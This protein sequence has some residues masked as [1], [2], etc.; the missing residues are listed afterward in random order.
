ML[1]VVDIGLIGFLTF[2]A[3]RDGMPHC[4]SSQTLQTLT[5]NSRRAGSLRITLLWGIGELVRGCR[6]ALAAGQ[7]LEEGVSGLV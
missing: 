2:H 5:P 7:W 6:I 3:Y 1:F 4:P